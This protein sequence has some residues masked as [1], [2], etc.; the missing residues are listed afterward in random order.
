VHVAHDGVQAFQIAREVKPVACFLDIG[1]P[2]MDG[3]ELAKRLKSAEGGAAAFLVATTGWG[4]PEDKRLSEESGFDM[5]MTKPIDVSIAA[6]V[7]AKRL[8]PD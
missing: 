5:H 4:N 7:L 3:Y 6:Q 1:M 8:R 2:G